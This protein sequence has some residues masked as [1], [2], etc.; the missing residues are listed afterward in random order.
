MFIIEN[1]TDIFLPIWTL[2]VRCAWCL[3]LH[4]SVFRIWNLNL[5]TFVAKYWRG[6]LRTFWRKILKAGFTRICRETFTP[7]FTH[8]FCNFVLTEKAVSL[9]ECMMTSTGWYCSHHPSPYRLSHCG[10]SCPLPPPWCPLFS[11]AC[12]RNFILATTSCSD[13]FLWCCSYTEWLPP[14]YITPYC[15]TSGRWI[16]GHCPGYCH[17]IMNTI[18][19]SIVL[20]I[21]AIL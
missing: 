8:F 1:I 10:W 9:L 6:D 4:T 13:S 5:R 18:T 11:P 21:V 19:Y 16:G 3:D 17:H 15:V 2:W 20:C 7:G 12:G 14:A